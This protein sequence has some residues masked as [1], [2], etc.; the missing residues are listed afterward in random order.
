MKYSLEHQ[1]ILDRTLS[2]NT[3]WV[4]Q[5]VYCLKHNVDYQAYCEAYCDEDKM[6]DADACRALENKYENITELY[7]DWGDLK[8][9]DA[10]TYSESFK[11]WLKSKRSLFFL[12][13]MVRTVNDVTNYV[14]RRDRVLLDIPILSNKKKMMERIAVHIDLVHALRMPIDGPKYKPHGEYNK[15]TQGS[16]KKAIYV[17]K[18][19]SMVKNGKSLSQTDIVIAAMQDPKNPF[20][21]TMTLIDKVAHDRGTFKKSLFNGSKVKMLVKASQDFDALVRNTIHGR[22]PDFR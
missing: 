13:D 19:Q 11:F 8:N 18:H 14:Q 10:S 4:R 20:K 3:L 22:F 21:W 7:N 15:A 2:R 1:K 12:D 17:A 9:I 6:H 5:W 16:V